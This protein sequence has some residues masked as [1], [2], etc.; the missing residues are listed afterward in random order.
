M[1]ETNLLFDVETSVGI[2][3]FAVEF[4]T[5]SFPNANRIRIALLHGLG[6]FFVDVSNDDRFPSGL[7]A[8]NSL[9]GGCGRS[10]DCV[11]FGI[12]RG[13]ELFELINCIALF[14]S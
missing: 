14:V 6:S 10:A 11:Q 8:I 2:R 7:L 3:V 5:Y 13:Y 9:G 4:L 1:C 12:N